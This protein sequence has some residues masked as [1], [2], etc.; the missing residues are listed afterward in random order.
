M[1]PQTFLGIGGRKIF[2]D[3]IWSSLR[4]PFIA[5]HK[6]YKKHGFYDF[7]QSRKKQRI[8][9]SVLMTLSKIPGFRNEIYK[10]RMK[11]EM[12]KPLQSVLRSK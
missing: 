9:S 1:M 12:I 4:F 11:N 10:K 3:E 5:D 6:Y 2:R 7:P 8:I